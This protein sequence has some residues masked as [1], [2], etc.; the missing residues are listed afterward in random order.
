MYELEVDNCL[1]IRSQQMM[2]EDAYDLIIFIIHATRIAFQGYQECSTVSAVHLRIIQISKIFLINHS[3]VYCLLLNI[4]QWVVI[5]FNIIRSH[6][7]QND[8]N[9]NDNDVLFIV[10]R[11]SCQIYPFCMQAVDHC[12]PSLSLIFTKFR[13][14][15]FV[16]LCL[17][18]CDDSLGLCLV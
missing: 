7:E 18:T 5:V 16:S 1:R 6:H 4:M 8:N 2:T 12:S 3:S 14:E 15:M 11:Y 13:T 9:D 17:D 10:I